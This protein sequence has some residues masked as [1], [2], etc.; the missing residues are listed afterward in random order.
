MTV[1]FIREGEYATHYPALKNGTP[2]KFY[3][4]CLEPTI[5]INIPYKELIKHC[6]ESR[7]IEHYLRLTVEDVFEQHLS[8]VEGFI[9]DNAEQRYLNFISWLG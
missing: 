9:F 2:S 6:D 1:N 3:F 4:Q 5:I 8:R 7:H